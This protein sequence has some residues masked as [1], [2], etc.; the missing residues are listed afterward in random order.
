ME[1]QERWLLYCKSVGKKPYDVTI[2]GYQYMTWIKDKVR[3]YLEEY[4][5]DFISDQDDFT[6]WIRKDIGA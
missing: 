4:G 5:L 2:Q 3:R 6:D 1:Y